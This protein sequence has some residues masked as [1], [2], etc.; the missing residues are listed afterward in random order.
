MVTMVLPMLTCT[1]GLLNFDIDHIPNPRPEVIY[2]H[3][4]VENVLTLS[5]HTLG[6]TLCV[7]APACMMTCQPLQWGM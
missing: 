5:L 6:S 4:K 1:A 7:L 3:D 2:S